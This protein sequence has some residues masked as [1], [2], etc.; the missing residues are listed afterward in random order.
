M[1]VEVFSFNNFSGRKW[2]CTIAKCQQAGKA[3]IS[4][5]MNA[6]AANTTASTAV[7]IA[8]IHLS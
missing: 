3:K 2:S 4:S 8:Y 5:Q 7:H 6:L 1:I